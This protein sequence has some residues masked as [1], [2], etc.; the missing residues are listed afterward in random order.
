MN[1]VNDMCEVNIETTRKIPWQQIEIIKVQE[2]GVSHNQ[3][4]NSNW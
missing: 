1:K 2:G 3:S 4:K